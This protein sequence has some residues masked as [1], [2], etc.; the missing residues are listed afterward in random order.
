MKKLE[1]G[2]SLLILYALAF[3][4]SMVIFG[5]LCDIIW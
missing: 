5:Y 4:I 3:T 1:N 2:T